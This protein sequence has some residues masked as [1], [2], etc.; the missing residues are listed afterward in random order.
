MLISLS[1]SEDV[2]MCANILKHKTSIQR[3]NYYR[4]EVLIYRSYLNIGLILRQITD[5]LLC[6]NHKLLNL[7]VS[8]F[9]K[10]FLSAK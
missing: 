3:I 9:I 8:V 5:Y 1:S 10:L 6:D 7:R 4:K 2:V